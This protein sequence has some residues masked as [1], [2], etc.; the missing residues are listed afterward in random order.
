MI[1][2][3]QIFELY[4]GGPGSG[5]HGPNCGRPTKGWSEMSPAERM[6]Q[7]GK[8]KEARK[9]QD[10][11]AIRNKWVAD[12]ILKHG[13]QDSRRAR[14]W[15]RKE[16]NRQQALTTPKK[17]GMPK[18]NKKKKAWLQKNAPKIGKNAP[19]SI[20]PQ[21]VSARR[22]KQQFTTN[23][24]AKVTIL[25]PPGQKEKTGTTW[26]IRESPYKGQF[27]QLFDIPSYF[28]PGTNVAFFM[29]KDPERERAVAVQVHRDFGQKS[30][31][32]TEIDLEQYDA[33]ARSRQ[34]TFS[35]MGKASGFLMKRYGISFKFK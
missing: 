22:V 31:S 23:S 1:S 12:Q 21:P 32:V 14:A 19:S 8:D 24:G 11:N 7:I 25:K 34:A 30:T 9:R 27:N 13:Q 26:L 4:S 35:N 17:Y 6:Q 29:A 3:A 33:M 28:K 16:Y 2:L 5:C 15:W 18:L 10:A 20:K